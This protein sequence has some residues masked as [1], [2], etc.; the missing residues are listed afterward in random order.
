MEAARQAQAIRDQ[1]SNLVE[2]FP[3]IKGISDAHFTPDSCSC[4]VV[5][6]NAVRFVAQDQELLAH[7]YLF[8]WTRTSEKGPT[9]QGSVYDFVELAQFAAYVLSDEYLALLMLGEG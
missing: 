9:L 7:E 6:Q 5:L 2:R 3:W 4:Q 8:N 1:V